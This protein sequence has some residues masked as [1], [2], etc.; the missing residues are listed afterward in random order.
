MLIT[1]R[2]AGKCAGCGKPTP[3]GSEID[4]VEK[5]AF[6]PACAPTDLLGDACAPDPDRIV[7]AER[8]GYSHV[9]WESLLLLPRPFTDESERDS[10]VPCGQDAVSPV[11]GGTPYEGIEP[12]GG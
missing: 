10:G 8:L 7:L 6:H 12:Q 1:A 9:P 3:R 2:F 4:Y 11:C 5:K